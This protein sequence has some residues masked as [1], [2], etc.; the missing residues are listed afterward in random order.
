MGGWLHLQS[1]KYCIKLIK[2]QII[3][4]YQTL[5]SADFLIF[6]KIL[7]EFKVNQHK[8][9]VICRITLRTSCQRNPTKQQRTIM[10]SI[11]LLQVEPRE[12]L[13]TRVITT[14]TSTCCS[15]TAAPL[16]LRR[17][18]QCRPLTR[19][20]WSMRKTRAPSEWSPRQR[21]TTSLRWT[22]SHHMSSV[23]RAQ[24]VLPSS[25]SLIQREVS[26]MAV[27]A[28]LIKRRIGT[29][30]RGQCL[31]PCQRRM[32]KRITNTIILRQ[33]SKDSNLRCIRIIMRK[34]SMVMKMMM[35]WLTESLTKLMRSKSAAEVY[36]LNRTPILSIL[37]QT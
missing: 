4:Q 23:M 19:R 11:C 29:L 34:R 24:T 5:M 25:R 3:H 2:N 21:A 12:A 26:G 28:H 1:M 10:I 7:L 30:I 13:T 22:T 32:R 36:T 17:P 14:T 9:H 37:D 31:K 15:S 33:I 20:V 16:A 35:R 18:S 27:G 6:H 8:L